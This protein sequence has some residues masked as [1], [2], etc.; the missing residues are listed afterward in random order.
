MPAAPLPADQSQRLSSLLRMKIL[1]TPAEERF[2]RLT[3]LARRLLRAPFSML[4]LLDQERQWFKSAQGTTL[5]ES[6]RAISFCAFTILGEQPL[7]VG[8][9]SSDPRFFD[10]PVVTGEPGVRFYAGIPIHNEEGYAVGTLCVLDTK[11][12]ELDQDDLHALRDLAAC[13]QTELQVLKLTASEQ[14]LLQEMDEV[15]RRA[16]V[17]ALTRCWNH[18][19]IFQ[20]L[21]KERA[22]GGQIS[23]I[24]FN[25][26]DIRSINDYWGQGV[27]DNVLREAADRLRQGLKPDDVLGRL[28]GTRFLV[29]TRSPLSHIEAYA[30][31]IVQSV[32]GYD[33]VVEG[34]AL[35]IKCSAGVAPLRG[36][37]DPNQA[38]LERAEKA[39]R[40]I[41]G[42]AG[43]MVALAV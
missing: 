35:Q 11:P 40:G 41:R 33:V 5:E 21:D 39:E 16:S 34:R 42:R 13:A 7:V 19:A 10:N 1:D 18:Q 8:D 32:A 6:P 36:N 43:S 30:A 20:I 23:I 26:E 27:G 9:A 28:S 3:R 22:R 25:I 31:S 2:D 15:R 29:V 24:L 38:L 17:D 14:E 12:R 37:L 4:T